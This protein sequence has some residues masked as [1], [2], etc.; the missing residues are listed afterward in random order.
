VRGALLRRRQFIKVTKKFESQLTAEAGGFLWCALSANRG[1]QNM[2]AEPARVTLLRIELDAVALRC[3]ETAL[4]DHSQEVSFRLPCRV[5]AGDPVLRVTGEGDGLG[6][7]HRRVGGE[8]AVAPA[9]KSKHPCIFSHTHVRAD[10]RMYSPPSLNDLVSLVNDCRL[11]IAAVPLALVA[12]AERGGCV[13][14]I[15]DCVSTPAGPCEPVSE[16][17]I[18][19]LKGACASLGRASDRA[20]RPPR[21]RPADSDSDSDSDSESDSDEPTDE[22]DRECRVAAVQAVLGELERSSNRPFDV[23]KSTA[24]N[25]PE[26]APGAWRRRWIEYAAGA[27]LALD[28]RCG[29]EF[30]VWL[31]PHVSERARRARDRALDDQFSDRSSI[32]ACFANLRPWHMLVREVALP[33]EPLGTLEVPL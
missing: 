21:R 16:R 12:A 29:F 26:G 6:L 24:L 1:A 20:A 7:G 25:C 28:S 9:S 18:L 5:S 31:A 17:D 19:E 2:P 32:R 14:Y 30:P 13:L 15:Y 4:R 22:R 10:D 11:G 27:A 33:A 8:M 3:I 23:L